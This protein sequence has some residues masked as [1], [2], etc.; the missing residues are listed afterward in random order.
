[1]STPNTD[2]LHP[3]SARDAL[4]ILIL[5]AGAIGGYYGARLIQAG[6]DVT[7]LVREARA[8]TLAQSGLSVHSDLGEAQFLVP[9]VT[10]GNVTPEYDL[11]LLACKAY[12]LDTAMAA[13]EPALK[14]RG[15]VLPLLNG[16]A[17]YDRLDARFGKDRIL[18][19]VAY[20]ATTLTP[21]G[22]IAHV[23]KG[24]TLIVGNRTPSAESLARA[25]YDIIA[26][27][28]GQRRLSTSIEQ[29]LWNKWVMIASGAMMT[30]LMRGNVGEILGTDHGRLL[31]QQAMHECAEVARL[32]G[33]ELAADAVQ[34]MHGLL[35]NESSTW[36]ASMAR[37]IA[38]AAPRI[39]A[40]DIVGD[41]VKR[42]V[43]LGQ[44]APLARTAFCHLQ[45][46]ARQHAI[47]SGNTQ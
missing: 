15:V 4:K 31:M 20:I 23:G 45:V 28:P 14:P 9:A 37:D 30:C 21:D 19:G 7:F 47:P 26:T 32:S 16:L 17:V 12:D 22:S 3:T 25:F 42:S 5:G 6:A 2:T 43:K 10:A 1:L 44:D 40:D 38:Q 18:G 27:T 29:D 24:D 34:T 33:F 39:E 36:A 13:I 35:E 11:V 8:K 41:I 46:Y